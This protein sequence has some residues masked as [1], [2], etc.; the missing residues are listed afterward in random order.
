MF[1]YLFIYL[2]TYIYLSNGNKNETTKRRKLMAA[3]PLLDRA[4]QWNPGESHPRLKL[5]VLH[6]DV[7]VVYSVQGFFRAYRIHRVF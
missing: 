4:L 3:G 5:W 2:H 7:G 1:I 6:R